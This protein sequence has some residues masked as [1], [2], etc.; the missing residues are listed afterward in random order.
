MFKLEL[1]LFFLVFFG[2]YFPQPRNIPRLQNFLYVK[3]SPIKATL[4]STPSVH[5]SSMQLFYFLG[6]AFLRAG[7]C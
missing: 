7:F 6:K 3:I 5:S 2:T 4:F 1:D